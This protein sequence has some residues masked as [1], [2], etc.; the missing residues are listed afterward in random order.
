MVELLL[1][2]VILLVI[3]VGTVFLYIGFLVFM[4]SDKGERLFELL[5]ELVVLYWEKVFED[6]EK[7]K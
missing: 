4:N 1:W 6:K 7:I 5:F 3:V 2:L